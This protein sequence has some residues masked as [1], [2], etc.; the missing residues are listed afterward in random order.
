MYEMCEWMTGL[1]QTLDLVLPGH[2]AQTGLQEGLEPVLPWAS[3]T[4]AQAAH[5]QNH[6]DDIDTVLTLHV[7]FAH[8]ALDHTN[9]CSSLLMLL[10]VCQSCA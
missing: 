2:H 8:L 7:L 9:V 3:H 5:H 10:Y 1:V 4:Y 6:R